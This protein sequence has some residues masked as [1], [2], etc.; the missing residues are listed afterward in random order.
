MELPAPVLSAAARAVNFTNEGG[1]NG[2]IRLLKNIAGL[3]LLQECRRSWQRQGQSYTWEELMALASNATP[4]VSIVNPDAAAF[5]NP[6]DMPSAIQAYCAQHGITVPQTPG[7]IVRCCLESL[8]LRYRTVLDT[9]RDLTGQDIDTIRIVGGGSQNQL[10]NRFTADACNL[11][12][13]AGP[14]EATALGNVLIQAL[15]IGA[16]PDLATGRR[17]IAESFPPTVI[18]PSTDRAAWDA[19]LA[20]FG[21]LPR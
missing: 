16:I 17:I 3:W 20:G 7:A 9:L 6:D 10:L 2:T 15:T 1:I 5:L 8:A 12:V 4:F 13:V 19:Q 14:V 18:E 11:P 21:R